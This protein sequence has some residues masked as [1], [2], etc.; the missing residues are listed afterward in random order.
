MKKFFMAA[1]MLLILGQLT[2]APAAGEESVDL[3]Q[4]RWQIKEISPSREVLMRVNEMTFLHRVEPGETLSGLARQTQVEP[5]LLAAMNFLEPED[6]LVAGQY[7]ILPRETRPLYTV[8]R[9][10]TLYSLARRFG[11]TPDYLASLNELVDPAALRVGQKLVVPSTDR[12]LAVSRGAVRL[13]WP[14]EGMLTSVF[15][16]RHGAFHSG[17]D[18]AAPEGTPIKAV[19]GGTVTYTGWL[20]GY[21]QAV[22]IRHGQ[23]METLYAHNSKILV[24]EGQSVTAG[25][26][27]SLMGQTGNA[28]G[29]NLHLEIRVDGQAR[30]PLIYL[31]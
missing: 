2:P 6:G 9:G 19:L 14:V 12:P 23:G 10:D 30:D 8:Q 15:G 24:R 21:G 4:V 1:V 25:Q 7:L 31:R 27:V 29:P 20:G 18:L 11:S 5:D 17:I 13:D 26:E 16:P 3:W 28:T 22:I